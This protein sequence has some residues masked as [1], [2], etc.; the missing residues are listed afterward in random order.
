MKEVDNIDLLLVLISICFMLLLFYEAMTNPDKSMLDVA[1]TTATFILDV[2]KTLFRWMI[3]GSFDYI[4]DLFRPE[5]PKKQRWQGDYM[6]S[7]QLY[8]MVM[9][10]VHPMADVD[11]MLYKISNVPAI[12]IYFTPAKNM[13]PDDVTLLA[14]G[15][16]VKFRQYLANRGMKF[17]TFSSY[18]ICR[19]FT[20]IYLYY[21]ELPEDKEP[22][23]SLYRDTTVSPV[24]ESFGE[25]YD[26]DLE[27]EFD[28]ED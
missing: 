17:P 23:L 12:V 16:L 14:R 11:I 7:Q 24:P 27:Q 6:L 15:L 10:H 1:K 28:D 2:F 3:H 22:F 19:D 9:N 8:A 5:P 21:A 25:I 4:K 13:S 18:T 26:E 20:E